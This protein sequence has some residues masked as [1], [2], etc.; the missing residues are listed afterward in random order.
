MKRSCKSLMAFWGAWLAAVIV[1]YLI[2][3][4][5]I[6]AAVSLPNCENCQYCEEFATY[7]NSSNKKDYGTIAGGM[8]APQAY[9]GTMSGGGLD[10]YKAP[11]CNNTGQ[12]QD[13]PNQPTVNAVT[14]T[15]ADATCAIATLPQPP[16]LYVLTNGQGQKPT[17]VLLVQSECLYD[18]P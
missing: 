13:Y 9:D 17:G 7:Y 18:S 15:S 10:I 5:G 6:S 12:A 1:G 8:P 11:Y 4:G 14:Y 2:S 3:R 16:G